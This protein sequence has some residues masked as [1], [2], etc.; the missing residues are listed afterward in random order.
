MAYSVIKM[1]QEKN[2][3]NQEHLKQFKNAYLELLEETY[4][5]TVNQPVT[6]VKKLAEA[7]IE[8]QNDVLTAIV[9]AQSSLP[10]R[11]LIQAN[12]KVLQFYTRQIQQGKELSSKAWNVFSEANTAWQRVAVE[13]EK[14]AVDA[15]KAWLE[16]SGI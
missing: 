5:L 16:T 3:P 13:A 2:S 1:A 12:N 10:V 9:N 8:A 7:S 6:A 4:E 15:Y 14:A 11:D